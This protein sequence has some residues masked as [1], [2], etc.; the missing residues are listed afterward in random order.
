MRQEDRTSIA[1]VAVDLIKADGIIDTREMDFMNDLKVKYGLERPDM[2]RAD[3]LSLADALN[4]L[5]QADAKTRQTL[6]EYFKQASLS[7]G[8]CARQEAL[9]LLGLHLM[10][11]DVCDASV[12]SV[13][14]STMPFDDTQVL[15]LENEY[16]VAIN[17]ELR[18]NYRQLNNELRLASF[19]LVYLP[20][21]SAHYLSIDPDMQLRMLS[22]LY[23]KVNP[24][25]LKSI[26]CK[27]NDLST[28]DF[29]KGQLI[30]KL[31]IQALQAIEPSLLIKIGESNVGG[32]QMS[33]FLVVPVETSMLKTVRALC[34]LLS[35]Y[36]DNQQINYLRESKRRFLLTGYYRQL[37]D[38]MMMK[39]GVRSNVVIDLIHGTIS[40]PQAGVSFDRLHRREKALYALFM[41]EVP[42]GINFMPPEKGGSLNKKYKERM[43]RIQDK[44]QRI[45][46]LFGGKDKVPDITQP[47]IRNT[48]ISLIKKQV[49]AYSDLL[50]RADDYTIKRNVYGIHELNLFKEQCYCMDYGTQP[51]QEQPQ[52]RLLSDDK[53][54]K[55][56]ADI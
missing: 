4:Q 46:T 13:D 42:Y 16:D 47:T 9:L 29:C 8:I 54:W 48:M 2:M 3:D 21:I 11:G 36:Y 26:I 34:D 44:Y 32:H 23:P 40:L 7:D 33:N 1:R 10:L 45:Y 25:R 56:I 5:S 52:A 20:R 30:Y 50:E 49:N 27:V 12:F 53:T 39:R 35:T 22:F 6:L 38:I 31:G 18:E 55:Q 41:V 24:D 28:S 14:T 17:S 15:Y 37:F 51:D 43:K 19:E